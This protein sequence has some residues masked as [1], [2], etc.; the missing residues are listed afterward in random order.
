MKNILVSLFLVTVL[1]SAA[2]SPPPATQRKVTGV[3]LYS[4]GKRVGYVKVPAKATVERETGTHIEGSRMQALMIIKIVL[5]GQAP[6][7]IRADE[8]QLEYGG[9]QYCRLTMRC[10]EPGVSVTVAIEASRGPGR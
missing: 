5:P 6:I 7:E 4:D 1:L 10:S 3:A 9:P 2:D 8:V